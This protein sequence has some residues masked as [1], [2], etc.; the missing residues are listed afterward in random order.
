MKDGLLAEL[1]NKVIEGG[2]I[3]Q[4]EALYLAG[5][6]TEELTRAADEIRKACCGDAFDVC[7]IVNGKSGRCPEDCKYCAQ[8]AHY[9]ANPRY[10]ELLGRDEILRAAQQNAM[11]GARRFSIVTSGKRLTDK[12]VETL[13]GLYRA[14]RETCG[15]SLCASHGLLTERQFYMLKEAGVERYHNN[16]ETSRT[17]FPQICTTHSYEDKIAAIRAA[18]SVGLCVCSGGIIGMGERM[19]DRI[20]MALTLKEL[21]ISSVPI[22]LLN[23]IK[24]TPMESR[25]AIPMEEACKTAAIFRFILPEAQLRLAGGRVNLADK[26]R[27]MLHAGINAAISGDM[28]TTTGVTLK[29]DLL[30]ISECGFQV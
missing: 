14:I 8:S 30:M 12:E 20:E 21:E 25:K 5:L 7:S 28:L 27:A 10:Y 26:G 11:G 15:I 17:Y 2:R 13:C 23:P 18:Q 6:E 24:G 4:K 29:S 9:D 1:K 16:L 3:T 19:E 22:N